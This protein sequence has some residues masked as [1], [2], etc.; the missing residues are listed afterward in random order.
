M[1]SRSYTP[2]C[3]LRPS[4]GKARL[5]RRSFLKWGLGLAA[6]ARG[7]AAQT[8]QKYQPMFP[9]EKGA[10]LRLLPARRRVVCPPAA[11]C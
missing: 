8:A 10:S 9:V 7:A 6:V 4:A 3:G 5:L 2:A 11:L 1:T